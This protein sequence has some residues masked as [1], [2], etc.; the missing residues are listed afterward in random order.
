M[1]FLHEIF[2]YLFASL[3]TSGYTNSIIYITYE[4]DEEQKGQ[5]TSV[6]LHS[7]RKSQNLSN[8]HQTLT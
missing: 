3:V 7:K 4:K 2:K 6:K 5:V 8:G 1:N